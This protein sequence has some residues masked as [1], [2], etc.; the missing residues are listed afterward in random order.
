MAVTKIAFP[1]GVTFVTP[2][3]QTL[4]A[5]DTESGITGSA[6]A[7]ISP[8]SSPTNVGS[9]SDQAGL[10]SQPVVIVERFFAVLQISLDWWQRSR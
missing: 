3:N 7:A 6:G 1:A 10:L 2:G 5:A 4:I 8:S 9:I